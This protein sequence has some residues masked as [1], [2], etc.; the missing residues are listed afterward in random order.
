MEHKKLIDYSQPS[1]NRGSSDKW[2]ILG[3]LF[4]VAVLMVMLF[5]GLKMRG[6]L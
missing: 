1:P 2:I 4:L 3:W 5:A 6:I